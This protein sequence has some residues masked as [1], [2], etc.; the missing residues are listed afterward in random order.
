MD[1]DSARRMADAAGVFLDSLSEAQ[2]G[3]AHLDFA[4]ALLRRHY[5]R[6]HS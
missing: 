3:K 1:T 6:D 2:R 4:D 5:R